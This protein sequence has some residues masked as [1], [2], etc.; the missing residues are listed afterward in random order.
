MSEGLNK[1]PKVDWANFNPTS[2]F[3]APPPALDDRGMPIVYQ[4]IAPREVKTGET[5][6][7]YLEFLLDP[8]VMKLGQR[9]YE[10]RFTRAS[11]KLFEKTK[12]DG[13]K[14][15]QNANK[16]G[17][18]L[19]SAQV[20]AAPQENEQYIAA[21]KMAGGK[22]IHFTIDW[23][24]YNKDNQ[25]RVDGY[26]AFPEDPERPGQ[27]KAILTKGETYNVLDRKGNIIETR[28]VKSDVLFANAR[29]RYFVDPT[30]KT[31]SVN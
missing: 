8:I 27:R 4:G 22:T 13:T 10:I 12:R 31:G 11:V 23:S 29:V 26:L 14:V 25:E 6:D 7:G 19:K 9:T 15:T 2:K 1:A 3:Q 5:E 21:V 16:V 17:T 18:F 28:T 30:R 20:N 24:A